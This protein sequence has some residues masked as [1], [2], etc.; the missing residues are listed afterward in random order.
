MP[1][2][3]TDA[4]VGSG[5]CKNV[6]PDCFLLPLVKLQDPRMVSRLCN[7]Q[8]C[9][10]LHPTTWKP[11]RPQLGGCCSHHFSKVKIAASICHHHHHQISSY[12]FSTG[13]ENP[14]PANI[15]TPTPCDHVEVSYSSFKMPWAKL[16]TYR[17][18]GGKENTVSNYRIIADLSQEAKAQGLARLQDQPRVFQ[19]W[20][21]SPDKY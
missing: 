20:H 12:D 8:C 18:S 16:V 19:N 11:P 7:H 9:F 17:E 4:K 5:N 21:Q 10:A 2:A 15:T 3:R 6:M 14:Q 13:C 1:A